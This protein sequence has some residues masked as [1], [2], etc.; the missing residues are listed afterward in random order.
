MHILDQK[1]DLNQ[2]EL[3]EKVFMSE[4]TAIVS[5]FAIKKVRHFY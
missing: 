4:D 1:P 3:F 5:Y 2:V